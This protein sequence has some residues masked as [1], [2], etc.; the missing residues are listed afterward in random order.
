MWCAAGKH[1]YLYHTR[2]NGFV[3]RALIK[4]LLAKYQVFTK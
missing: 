3:V 2:A 1:N 4:H